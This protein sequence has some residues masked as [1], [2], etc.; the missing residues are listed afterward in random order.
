MLSEAFL[1]LHA[2]PPKPIVNI[3]QPRFSS[4]TLTLFTL[5]RLRL[6]K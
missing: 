3:I 4:R 6:T 1:G 5:P 2:F